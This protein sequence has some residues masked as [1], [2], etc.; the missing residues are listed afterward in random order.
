MSMKTKGAHR[1]AD[2]KSVLCERCFFTLCDSLLDWM[3]QVTRSAIHLNRPGAFS[4]GWFSEAVLQGSWP[5]FSLQ[6]SGYDDLHIAADQ[7]CHDDSEES[8]EIDGEQRFELFRDL[9]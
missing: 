4:A 2:Q 6:G 8:C 5:L 1:E 9:Q 7:R 3:D